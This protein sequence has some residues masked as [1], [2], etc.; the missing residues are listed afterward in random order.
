MTNEFEF[1]M[2]M[3]EIIYEKPFSGEFTEVSFG[4]DKGNTLWVKFSDRDGIQEWI[5]KFGCGITQVMRV[6]KAVEPDIFIIIAG[7][8]AYVLNATT[9]RLLNYYC[10]TSIEDIVY[11]APTNQFI[12]A[13][14]HLRIIENGH[15]VW[16]SRR[17]ALDG[18]SGMS[19]QD[20]ILTGNAVTG[21]EGESELFTFDLDTRELIKASTIFSDYQAVVPA[22]K[23]WEFWK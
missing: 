4:S 7:G 13:D 16:T 10:D 8:F 6:T 5:G 1:P 18:V 17:I 19:I 23:W 11:D 15:E 20:R 12:A 21:D 14:T 9:H 2:E 22:K 3:A